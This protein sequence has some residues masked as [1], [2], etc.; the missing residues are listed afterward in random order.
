MKEKLK[1]F[2]K[3]WFDSAVRPMAVAPD[4]RFVYL[5]ISFF[6][7]FFEYD[8]KE[9]KITRVAELPVPEDVQKKNYSGYQLNS[10]HHGIAINREGTKLCVAATM[11]AY[12]AIVHRDTFEYTLVPVGPKPYWST[13]SAVGGNCYVSVSEQ[14]R[15]AVISWEKEKEIASVPVGRH[16]QRVRT[17]KMLLSEL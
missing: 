16:P 10:A 11:S 9:D 17:G 12:A 15:V 3:P 1:E 7:G 6:H 14:D 2:G 4:E 13:E 8:M 5:Q